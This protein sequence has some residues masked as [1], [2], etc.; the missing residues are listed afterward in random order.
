MIDK[1]DECGQQFEDGL[2][3]YLQKLSAEYDRQIAEA[4]Q[5]SAEAKQQSLNNITAIFKEVVNCYKLACSFNEFDKL[6][7][8]KPNVK[9]A[10]DVSKHFGFDYKAIIHELCGNGKRVSKIL[11]NRI[12]TLT[13]GCSL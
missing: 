12:T 4:K 9:D 8:F 7:I 10:I 13:D 3:E 5:R 2:K 11:Q 6:E 1:A